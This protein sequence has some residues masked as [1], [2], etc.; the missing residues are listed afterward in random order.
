MKPSEILAMA[1][2]LNV[3]IKATY[4]DLE[5]A[6]DILLAAGAD[7]RG[8][9]HQTDV[10]F[11]CPNGRLKLR[12]GNIEHS[13]IFY[14]RANSAMPKG[15]AVNMTQLS[16][17][18]HELQSVLAAA[19]GVKVAVHK[20]REIYFIDNVKFHLDRVEGLGSFAEIEAI[21][22]DGNIG[23]AKLNEQCNYYMKLLG[24][25]PSHLLTHSYSDML[26]K[27]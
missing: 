22:K 10:Y 18:S 3:E 17:D 24:I 14:A 5:K 2:H 20:A 25:E 21:D 13:L 4:N 8:T 11:H 15:S 27:Q 7:Y 1:A 19:W 6:R 9:D 26:E 16:G 12:R 23:Q